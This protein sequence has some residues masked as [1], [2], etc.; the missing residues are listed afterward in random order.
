METKQKPMA[1]W[2]DFIYKKQEYRFLK[3]RL[4]MVDYEGNK[5]PHSAPFPSMIVIFRAFRIN[6]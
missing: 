3:G 5:H 4:R 2:I 6:S 1:F